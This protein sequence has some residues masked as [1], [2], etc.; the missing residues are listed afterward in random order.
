[1]KRFLKKFFSIEIS[2]LIVLVVFFPFLWILLLNNQSVNVSVIVE[3]LQDPQIT[4]LTVYPNLK[5]LSIS[6]SGEAIYNTQLM[7]LEDQEV[8][9]AVEL[10][11]ETSG[12]FVAALDSSS[13]LTSVGSH[14]VIAIIEIEQDEVI[15]LISEIL[16]YSIDEEFNVTLDP[17]SGNDVILL[18]DDIT[19]DEFKALQNKYQLSVLSSNEYERLKYRRLSYEKMFSW[20]T[21]FQWTIY[22]ITLVFVPYLLIRRWRRKKN[23]GKSFWDLGNGVYLPK[24]HS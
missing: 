17:F 15:L 1:M 6:I 11:T 16:A 18:T 7:W 14:Q 3:P 19:E 9:E 12:Y 24:D 4:T 8:G 5:A 20:F 2:E 13:Q 10:T 23:Q 21:V 22:I